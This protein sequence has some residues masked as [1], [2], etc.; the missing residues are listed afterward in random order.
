MAMTSTGKTWERREGFSYWTLRAHWDLGDHGDDAPIPARR[1]ASEPTVTCGMF[2]AWDTG[3]APDDWVCRIGWDGR[4]DHWMTLDWSACV[5]PTAART[6]LRHIMAGAAPSRLPLRAPVTILYDHAPAHGAPFPTV[7]IHARPYGGIPDVHT[8]HDATLSAEQAMTLRVG[9]HLLAS[10]LEADRAGRG[11]P[12][13]P[14]A[15]MTAIDHDPLLLPL[16]GHVDHTPPY[17]G[18]S[19]SMADRGM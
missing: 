12:H 9:A 1:Y 3:L 19:A 6:T 11:A 2:R 17:I 18:G 5:M 8:G 14:T 15:H 10:F 7:T 13:P 4:H 16:T